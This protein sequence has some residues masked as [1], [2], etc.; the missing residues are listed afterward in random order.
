VPGAII[1]ILVLVIVIPVAFVMTMSIVAA[2]LGWS[3]GSEVDEN[4]AGTEDLALA[5]S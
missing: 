5:D 1:I 4:Y 2:L 3:V